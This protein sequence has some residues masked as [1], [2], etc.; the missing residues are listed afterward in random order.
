MQT[1]IYR[2]IALIIVFNYLFSAE[3]CAGDIHSSFDR[4]Q[5]EIRN[6]YK[7]K[8]VAIKQLEKRFEAAQVHIQHS[9]AEIKSLDSLLRLLDLKQVGHQ[10][11]AEKVSAVLL[12]HYT[13]FIDPSG[14]FDKEPRDTNFHFAHADHLM[15]IA[16]QISQEKEKLHINARRWKFELLYH[17]ELF[18]EAR[19]LAK[20]IVEDSKNNQI[21]SDSVQFIFENNYALTLLF[22]GED[23]LAIPVLES[24][25]S[26]RKEKKGMQDQDYQYAIQNLARSYFRTNNLTKSTALFEYLDSILMQTK[27]YDDPFTQ[28]VKNDL[29]NVYMGTD[30]FEPAYRMALEL[31]TY[32]EKKVGKSDPSYLKVMRSYIS[33][34]TRQKQFFKAIEIA[35][36]VLDTIASNYGKDRALYYYISLEY[37][38]CLREL[39]EPEKAIAITNQLIQALEN[40]EGALGETFL[41]ALEVNSTILEDMDKI[42]EA[43]KVNEKIVKIIE[44]RYGK[45]YWQYHST[46]TNRAAM[47]AKAGNYAEGIK[48]IESFIEEEAEIYGENHYN[49][50]VSL[51]SLAALY[52]NEKNFSKAEQILTRAIQLQQNTFTKGQSDYQS[53]QKQLANLYRRTNRL[54]QAIDLMWKVYDKQRASN[55]TQNTNY[56]QSLYLLANMLIENRQISEAAQISQELI[57]NFEATY[58]QNSGPA[59]SQYYGIYAHTLEMKG[60]IQEAENAYIRLVQI[61]NEKYTNTYPY[62]SDAEKEGLQSVSNQYAYLAMA[63][64]TRH[65]KRNPELSKPLFDLVA[66]SKLRI[67][68]NNNQV[69]N[70]L[71]ASNQDSL[72]QMYEEYLLLKRQLVKLDPNQSDNTESFENLNK[73]A[74]ELEKS[75]QLTASQNWQESYEENQLLTKIKSSLNP[76]EVAVEYFH[77]PVIR[78]MKATDTILYAALII[79]PSSTIP[80][81]VNLGM[82]SKL[83]KI[84]QTQAPNEQNRINLQYQNSELYNFVWRPIEP[85]LVKKKK[86]LLSLTGQLHQINPVAIR[87]TKS[88]YLSQKYQMQLVMNIAQ[89]LN[90]ET[91]LARPKAMAVFGGINFD[92][93]QSEYTEPNPNSY[94]GYSAN[95][96]GF[97]LDPNHP[98]KRWA[99]LDGTKSEVQKITQI[100][101]DAGIKALNYMDNKASEEQFKSLSGFENPEVIHLATHGFY[102]PS[103]KEGSPSW[104]NENIQYKLIQQKN[105]LLRSGLLF[106]GANITWTGEAAPST[107]ED[108]ILTALEASTLIFPQTKLVVLSACETALGANHGQEGIYGLQRAFRMAGIPN[109]I[110]SLW[111]IPDQSTAIFMERFYQ[112]FLAQNKDI[113]TAFRDTQNEM[114]ARYP[115][116]PYRWAGFVLVR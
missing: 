64:F 20:K 2:L 40:K 50:I 86:I 29:I 100:A 91:P 78:N 97:R 32:L 60:Q 24:I 57:T 70:S 51:N 9:E 76:N 71:L 26:G 92:T 54:P 30:N 111:K 37:A 103:T 81:F 109:L 85:F 16:N 17:F 102:F 4:L 80:A 114:R 105:P 43:L 62:L 68:Q 11:L 23:A 101:S 36:P 5:K 74:Y 41:E 106:S 79:D 115:K 67:L 1:L 59:A 14:I 90:L 82:E 58:Q 33:I 45:K 116:D 107:S 25:A 35:N 3:L 18:D 65:I 38:I 28:A 15:E 61:I 42:G 7:Q 34:L 88:E 12:D 6:Q 47:L 52:T 93:P 22:L 46:L 77:F 31:S 56:F 112:N 108:G 73:R 99:Y 87:N 95:I 104:E 39:G 21:Y 63:F 84:L 10:A 13:S 110:M 98:V 69:K 49:H 89:I 8:K 48:I 96:R 19:P 44:E 75:I 53:T 94:D 72:K 66:H 113:E 27:G 83:Q 55:L